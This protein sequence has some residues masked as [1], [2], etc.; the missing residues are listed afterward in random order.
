MTCVRATYVL[1]I[2][3]MATAAHSAAQTI[4]T[5]PYVPSQV[6]VEWM[7]PLYDDA[8][9][10]SGQAVFVSAGYL[11]NEN[12]EV[13]A[14]VPV[15]V[16][17]AVAGGAATST[18]GNPY[19][20][21]R[22]AGVDWPF[23]VEVGG[24][25]GLASFGGAAGLDPLASVGRTKAFVPEEYSGHLALNGRLQLGE[26][27]TARLRA[28]LVYA[29]HPTAPSGATTEQAVRSH[30]SVQFWREDEWVTI[31]LA[32]SARTVL[33]TQPGPNT[34]FYATG[35]VIFNTP[36]VRPGL[37]LSSPINSTVRNTAPYVLGLSL[38]TS[39]FR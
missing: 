17:A 19:L 4:W 39:L 8:T 35:T 11:I 14:E 7:Q 29:E 36:Y 12:I 25:L 1:M 33:T 2:L 9:G 16:N 3:W 30:Y 22:L 20:G 32:G 28:G 31:G 27:L 24:R 23:L 10:R 38:S 26:K 34:L 21:L 5:A 37:F 18:V 13:V 15:S 6:A